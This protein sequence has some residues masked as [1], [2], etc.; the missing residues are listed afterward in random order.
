MKTLLVGIFFLAGCSAAGESLDDSYTVVDGAE[1]SALTCPTT[2]LTPDDSLLNLAT[3]V[4]DRWQSAHGCPVEIADGG[5]PVYDWAYVFMNDEQTQ[6]YDSDPQLQYNQLC[7]ARRKDLNSP[8]QEIY[9]ST[10][11][12]N[13]DTAEVLA[14]ELGHIWAKP[15]THAR[16]GIGA[17]ANDTGRTSWIT[18]GTLEWVCEGLNCARFNP[19][20]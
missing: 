20:R 19:E 13:C 15:L 4:A 2:V 8:Q 14:H 6:V 18:P 10:A 9:L 1:V 3:Q 12:D 7:G 16:D 11:N 17:G 5:I